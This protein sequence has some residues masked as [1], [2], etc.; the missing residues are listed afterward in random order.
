MDMEHIYPSSRDLGRVVDS[1]IHAAGMS[2]REVAIKAGI[3][4]NTLNRRING[5]PFKWPELVE[6]ARVIGRT[7]SSLIADAE[8]YR[9]TLDASTTTNK[10]A[11]A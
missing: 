11:V 3:S 10:K 6:V 7:A 9:A 2:Q 5:Q 8:V 4:A 1:A